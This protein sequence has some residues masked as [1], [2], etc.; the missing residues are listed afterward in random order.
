MSL[1]NRVRLLAEDFGQYRRTI[2]AK[3]KAEVLLSRHIEAQLATLPDL[4]SLPRH[5]AGRTLVM[6]LTVGYGEAELAP[7]IESLRTCGYEGDVTLVTFD[8]SIATSAYLKSWSVQELSFESLPFLPMSMN[9]ARMLK[10]L[11]FLRNEVL[12]ADGAHRYDYI[13]LADVRDIVFQGDPFARVD[14]ADV[15][16]Y[17]EADRLIG[18]C[19]INSRWME[20]AFGPEVRRSSASHRISCAGTLIATPLGLMEYLLQMVLHIC[21]SRPSVRQSGIDQAIHNYLMINGLVANAT[22]RENGLEVMTV[23][24]GRPDFLSVAEDGRI[25]NPDGSFSETIHQYDRNERL[26]AAVMERYRRAG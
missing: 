20:Q 26:N 13:L 16:Y 11:E 5:R 1:L 6:G 15:Y 21:R 4:R 25:R 9:S 22:I 17:L 3:Q 18:D 19:P 7:F 24:A 8:T 2:D 14:G 10:Y 23:P 12:G